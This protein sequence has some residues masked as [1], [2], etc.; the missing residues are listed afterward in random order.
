MSSVSFQ[1]PFNEAQQRFVAC[2]ICCVDLDQCLFPT[3]TQAALGALAMGRTTVTPRL[4]PKI[5]QLIS[6]GSYIARARVRSLL[7]R[8][9][10]NEELMQ[11]F[12][13]VMTGMPV[14]L[15][16]SLARW[17]PRVSFPG[18]RDALAR[19]TK[20]MPTGMLSFSIQ[21]II[22][23]YRRTHGWRGQPI[24][25]LASG[26]PVEVTSSDRGPVLLGCCGDAADLSGWAKLRTL[27][28][29]MD[30]H[31]ASVPL[32]IGHGPDEV[33]M[34]EFARE[35]G[36]LS[37]GFR[38]KREWADRFDI[39]VDALTWRPVTRLLRLLE[40]VAEPVPSD[41]PEAPP[42]AIEASDVAEVGVS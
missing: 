12:S 29:W 30:E 2:D 11:R 21:P 6:G 37:I 24:F 27:Q 20:R 35:Q 23:A 13:D 25:D 3:F 41:P 8:R 1:V 40:P 31:H 4:W 17:L 16:E 38:P 18:W 26:T 22:D 36:G 19:I 14:D 28:R 9:P 33:P 7:G 39:V 5:G 15:I 10:S 32:V 42:D 34:A